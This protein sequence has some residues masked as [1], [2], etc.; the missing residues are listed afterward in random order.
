MLKQLSRQCV[1]STLM[2]MKIETL[3][4]VEH[5]VVVCICFVYH[6]IFFVSLLFPLRQLNLTEQRL[7]IQ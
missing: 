6:H 1:S 7:Y 5:A 2:H 4:F 3:G